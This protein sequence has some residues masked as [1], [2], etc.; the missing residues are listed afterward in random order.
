MRIGDTAVADVCEVE[1]DCHN[2]ATVCDRSLIAAMRSLACFEVSRFSCSSWLR[3]TRIRTFTETHGGRSTGIL[4]SRSGNTGRDR[5]IQQ[6]YS[7]RVVVREMQLPFRWVLLSSFL[8]RWKTRN[9]FCA[10]GICVQVTPC[11]VFRDV[12]C[13]SLIP[14]AC[15]ASVESR[16]SIVGSELDVF[17]WNVTR[18]NGVTPGHCSLVNVPVQVWSRNGV[19]V[20][21]NSRLLPSSPPA[22]AD[23]DLIVIVRLTRAFV[24]LTRLQRQIHS[25]SGDFVGSSRCVTLAVQF[26]RSYLAWIGFPC[27]V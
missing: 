19:R 20:T 7:H 11:C 3:T 15:V 26:A 23:L 16:H 1:S 17:L 12:G 9:S 6:R 8:K 18:S 22:V 4:F 2:S 5:R 14:A 21:L 27:G 24:R 25:A 13:E 10:L